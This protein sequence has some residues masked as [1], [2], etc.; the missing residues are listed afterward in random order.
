MKGRGKYGK[1]AWRNTGKRFG[2][3]REMRERGN[4][5]KELGKIRERGLE[6]YRAWAGEGYHK[7]R[8][9]GKCV[10]IDRSE[11]FQ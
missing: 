4:T 7:G 8:K 6:K 3:I 5:S 11:K 1:E 10:Y 2:D 9:Q